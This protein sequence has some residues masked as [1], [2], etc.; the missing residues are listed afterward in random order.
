MPPALTSSQLESHVWF[1]VVLV[2]GMAD[3]RASWKFAVLAIKVRTFRSLGFPPHACF[4]HPEGLGFGDDG[5]DAK[6]RSSRLT[7][8]EWSGR[9]RPQSSNGQCDAM[10]RDRRSKGAATSG[11][12]GRRAGPGVVHRGEADLV[13][14][15]SQR[16]RIIQIWIR[17]GL[18]KTWN[19]SSAVRYAARNSRRVF[20]QI[21]LTFCSNQAEDFGH[22]SPAAGVDQHI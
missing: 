8:V 19:R 9:N 11:R 2:P 16:T 18:S 12:R 1:Q 7:A 21:W 22:C 20:T 4:F 5:R 17:H 10:P 6:N 15:D 13:E 14:L 3:G